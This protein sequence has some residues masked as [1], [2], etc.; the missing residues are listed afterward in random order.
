MHSLCGRSARRI[1]NTADYNVNNKR[2][3]RVFS[4]VSFAHV[5]QLWDDEAKQL[6]MCCYFTWFLIHIVNS[7]RSRSFA[8]YLQ[9]NYM[10]SITFCSIPFQFFLLSFFVAFN[11]AVALF[12]MRAFCL[13]SIF[14]SALIQLFSAIEQQCASSSIL[15]KDDAQS[16]SLS[17]AWHCNLLLWNVDFSSSFIK[18]RT[19]FFMIIFPCSALCCSL[20]STKRD[21]FF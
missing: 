19:H 3:F 17:F 16:L 7:S 13:L 21:F 6:K 10:R 5:K 8:I 12:S 20:Q 15:F 2:S 4:S 14:A 1:A 18:K 11:F 9:T